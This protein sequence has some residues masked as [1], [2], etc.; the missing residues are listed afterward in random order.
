MFMVCLAL[1]VRYL[2][3]KRNSRNLLQ[4]MELQ[5]ILLMILLS[6]MLLIQHLLN[7]KVFAIH[8]LSQFVA[9]IKNATFYL[10]MYYVFF[11]ASKP[12]KEERRFWLNWLKVMI[13]VIMPINIG[14]TSPVWALF[15]AHDFD[16]KQ[17]TDLKFNEKRLY[18]DRYVCTSWFW[19]LNNVSEFIMVIVFYCFWKRIDSKVTK[20][21][22]ADIKSG[23]YKIQAHAVQWQSLRS[24]RST[25]QLYMVIESYLVVYGII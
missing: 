15:G 20:N 18:Y 21:I 9:I 17:R 2:S 6:I 16:Y 25:L 5:T 7:Y 4:S 12:L 13:C 8:G 10:S 3:N 1:L 23:G 14:M 22:S 24:L 19:P 11:M